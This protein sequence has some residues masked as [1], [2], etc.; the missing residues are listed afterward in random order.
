MPG[1]F[2]GLFGPRRSQE[3]RNKK[4]RLEREAKEKESD[5]MLKDAQR[6]LHEHY[7]NAYSSTRLPSKYGSWAE[8]EKNTL[9]KL[10][11]VY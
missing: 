11:L 6:M 2:D 5:E 7:G 10:S 3:Q 8:F 1:F 9:N 4:E